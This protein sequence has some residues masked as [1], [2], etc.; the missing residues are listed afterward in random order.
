MTIDEAIKELKEMRTD[1]WTDSRQMQ[2]IK[3]A[4]EALKRY[5]GWIPVNDRLPAE[6]S[7]ILVCCG[8]GYIGT[9]DYYSYGF[10]DCKDEVVAWMPLPEQYKGEQE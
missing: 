10:D 9:D 7:H 5:K 3:L 2:A 8:D 6:G 4:I 1:P